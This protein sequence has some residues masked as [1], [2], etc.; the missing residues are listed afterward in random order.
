MT[1]DRI[2]ERLRRYRRAAKKTLNEV[3]SES[4]LTASFLSQ[5]ERNLT[6]ISISSLASIATDDAIKAIL[7]VL[8][9]GAPK[10]KVY[11]AQ[12]ALAA[13]QRLELDGQKEA[14]G[15]LRKAVAAAAVP[16]HIQQAAG[17]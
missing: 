5:A 3:A 15:T 9:E 12:A 6:G 10:S 17:K 16:S 14:A 1:A 11:A 8:A 4:G 7:S 13:A 2:G